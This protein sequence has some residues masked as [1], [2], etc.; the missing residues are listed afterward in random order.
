M[1]KNLMPWLLKADQG[2]EG[3]VMRKILPL[4]LFVITASA[5]AGDLAVLENMGFSPDGRYFMFGQHV[6]ITGEGM[7]YAE[8]GIIDVPQN[9]F[10]SGGWQK[11]G[12]N[13]PLRPNQ[14]SRGALYELFSENADLKDRFKI[15]HLEQGRLL[16]TRS[17]GDDEYITDADGGESVPTLHF[18]DFE[19]GREYEL[20]LYQESGELSG[21]K[22]A[23]FH[24]ELATRDRTG[25]VADYSVGRPGFM[26]SGVSEYRIVRV[27]LG[28]KGKSLVIG[29]AK[30]GEDLSIRYM[31]ETL[32]LK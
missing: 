23:S 20:A 13:V 16:Y 9:D 11:G 6:L 30:V 21:E 2:N 18:R 8:L 19:N 31:A 27:W 17:N 15:N 24:I 28:P 14:D 29:V 3:V 12:W 7:A 26:R 1:G 5:Y 4:L 32:R 22:A 25:S 10:V